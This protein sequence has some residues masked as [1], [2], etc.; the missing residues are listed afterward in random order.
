MDTDRQISYLEKEKEEALEQW[1]NNITHSNVRIPLSESK[2][3][4][5]KNLVISLSKRIKLILRRH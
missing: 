5:R 2:R 3:R 4:K 1:R